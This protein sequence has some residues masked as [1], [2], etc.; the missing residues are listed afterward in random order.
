MGEKRDASR[1]FQ[2]RECRFFPCHKG[3]AEEEFNCLF[4]FCPLYTLGKKCGGNY[5][6][7]DKGIKSCKD[8][9]FPHI[10]E[11]YESLTGRFREIAEVVR[12]MDEAE[13]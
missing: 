1:F 9:T 12:R 6:Y 7:T 11:N 13:G 10:A 5:T 3:V 2:N 4:C 8:C